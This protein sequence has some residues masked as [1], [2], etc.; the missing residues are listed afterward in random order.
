MLTYELKHTSDTLMVTLKG[1]INEK[2]TEVF[3][4]LSKESC[5]KPWTLH[6]QG[7]DSINSL[8]IRIWT[9]FLRK[10]QMDRPII[11]TH[12][13]P[14]F[15]L[16]MNII[17]GFTGAGKIESFYG[18]FFCNQCDAEDTH[19]FETQKSRAALI[20]EAHHHKCPHCGAIMEAEEDE[21][22]F[23]GFLA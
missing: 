13:S 21:N 14:T 12:C 4:E 7:I 10:V 11:L 1:A 6:L 16:Q 23:F 3:T 17:A 2:S 8:G 22:F 15:V 20:E 9:N 18:A 19:F 5:V